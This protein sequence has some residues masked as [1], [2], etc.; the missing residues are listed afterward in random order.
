MI[1]LKEKAGSR[2]HMNLSKHPA[3]DTKLPG[4]GFYSFVNKAW[5]NKHHIPA[6]KSELSVSDE[7]EQRTD[8]ELMEILHSLPH[9]RNVN[10]TPK[11]SKE[12][13]Q[14]LGFLWKNKSVKSE[15]SYLRVC[16]NS[17]TTFKNK[18][19]IARFLGWL[20]KCSVPTFL[21]LGI[22]EELEKPYAL[23]PTL[24]PGSLLLPLEYYLDSSLKSSDTWK[25][26]EEF[27]GLCA[28]ELG[29]PFLYK[30]IQGEINLAKHLDASSRSDIESKT[31][32]KLITW[33]SFEW[34]GFMEGLDVPRWHHRTWLLDSPERLR[35]ILDWI[36]KEDTDSILAILSLD[37]ITFAAPSLR[38]NI[39][40][41]HEKLFMK[42]LRG[43]KTRPPEDRVFLE[44]IKSVL[45]DALCNI[46]SEHHRNTDLVK[47][48]TRLIEDIRGSAVDVMKESTMFSK[49]TLSNIVEK[50][51]R[52]RFEIGKGKPSPLPNVTYTPDSFLH[53]VLEIHSERSKM[54]LD[55]TGKPTDKEHSSYPCFI[56]NASYFEETNH[57]VIPWGIL[58]W[59]FYCKDA[60]LGW[61]HGGIGATVGHEMTHGFDL[62]GSMYSPRGTYK[63]WWTRKNR[64]SFK[65]RTRKVSKFFSKFRH[66]GQKIDGEKTLSENWA[67]L[68]GLKISLKSLNI[69]LDSSNASQ[70]ERKEAHRNFF[71]SYAISWRTLVRKEKML[72]SM[73]TSVHAPS[74]DRVDRI[75]PQFQEWYEAFDIKESDALFLKPQKRLKFF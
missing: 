28:I 26:Y 60:P 51:H 38:P 10:L 6:W 19:D 62:Q 59:P 73:L 31:G 42:S 24:A 17:L 47:D 21:E 50:I 52:M 15:E 69:K 13:L 63:E 23:R 35:S 57:I 2:C 25:A 4:E 32:K 8:K 66:L 43:I 5:L 7:M 34:Q 37:L 61:N 67:D 1:S 33:T 56:T 3:S 18:S 9:I 12:H 20:I 44:D 40:E 53:T 65:K 14:L 68:G 11:T 46:Y 64:S 27:V 41:A 70:E 72:F 29:I 75:V 74:E 58:Q 30:A 49:K 54:I 39:K 55:L 45:P 71:V 36:C 48:V 22:R 16:L